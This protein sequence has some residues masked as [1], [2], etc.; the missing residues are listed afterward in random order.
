M[1][2]LFPHEGAYPLHSDNEVIGT[3]LECQVT[4]IRNLLRYVLMHFLLSIQSGQCVPR[5]VFT[6]LVLV[7]IFITVC[8]QIS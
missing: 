1:V 3:E 4:F 7:V 2:A 6:C 8:P 5:L